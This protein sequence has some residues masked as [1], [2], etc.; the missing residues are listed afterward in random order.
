[1]KNNAKDAIKMFHHLTQTTHVK[2]GWQKTYINWLVPSFCMKV[3]KFLLSKTTFQ[4][5]NYVHEKNIV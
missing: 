2:K 3:K 1:M 5:K 4:K